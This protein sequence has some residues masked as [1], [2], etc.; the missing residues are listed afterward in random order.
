MHPTDRSSGSE[1]PTGA[2]EPD[3]R[4]GQVTFAHGSPGLT[5]VELV[6]EP[7]RPRARWRSWR[8]ALSCQDRSSGGAEIQ[9][10]HGAGPW[11]GRPPHGGEALVGVRRRAIQGACLRLRNRRARLLARATGSH[12]GR[13][14]LVEGVTVL[15]ASVGHSKTDER[16]SHRP[17]LPKL[18]SASACGRVR[19][20]TRS[21]R[22]TSCT[23]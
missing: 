8:Q 1:T 5:D 3:T 4:S 12:W 23:S 10:A 6:C 21:A 19:R 18:L 20:A 22:M 9:P 14:A 13:V 7:H 15:R 2:A 11:A 16:R 17:D